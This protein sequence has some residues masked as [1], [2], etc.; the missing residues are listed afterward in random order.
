MKIF[1]VLLIFPFLFSCKHHA[2][3]FA[4]QDEREHWQISN[5][6]SEINTYNELGLLDTTF[7]HIVQYINNE[8]A[9]EMDDLIT[10][11]YDSMK[12]LISEKTYNLKKAGKL[13]LYDTKSLTYDSK[14][15]CVL[16]IAKTEDLVSRLYKKKY[17]DSNRVQNQISILKRPD[18]TPEDWT[19]DSFKMHKDD[20]KIPYYDTFRTVN[21]YDKTGESNIVIVQTNSKPKD[22]ITMVNFYL[23]NKKLK[24]L[25]I[26]SRGDTVNTTTYLYTKN[27]R[28]EIKSSADFKT[29][30]IYENDKI[31]ESISLHKKNNYKLR[32]VYKYDSKG[33]EIQE[34]TYE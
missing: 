16:S 17:D 24:T 2:K 7:E 3:R 14:G 34:I 32:S 8:P 27:Q 10:R 19:V 6:R 33:N 9:F 23:E 18:Q 12:N 30:I 22:T 15:N 5:K 25:R 21:I 13:E 20:K 26:N 28:T 11:D 1:F 31:I 4:N 29:T